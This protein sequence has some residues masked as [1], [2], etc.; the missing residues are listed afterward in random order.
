MFKKIILSLICCVLIITGISFANDASMFFDRFGGNVYPINNDKIRMKSEV[1]DVYVD[2]YTDVHTG[3]EIVPYVECNFVFENTGDTEETILMGFPGDEG[4]ME[5]GYY[6]NAIQDFVAKV[7]GNDVKVAKQTEVIKHKKTGAGE[8]NSTKTWFTWEVKFRPKEVKKIYNGYTPKWSYPS[9]GVDE[10][11]F[12]Y[13]ITTG[14]GWSGTIGETTVN[15]H[16]SNRMKEEWDYWKTNSAKYLT[17]EDDKIIYHRTDYEP[18]D[19]IRFTVGKVYGEVRTLEGKNICINAGHQGKGNPELERYS[20]ISDKKKAKVTSGAKGEAEL[21]LKIAKIL[22]KY[23]ECYGANVMMIRET[24][25]VNISNVERALEGNKSDLVL[26]IHCNGADNKKVWG[27]WILSPARDMLGNSDIYEPSKLLANYLSKTI[28][29]RNIS[30]HERSDLTGLNWSKVPSIFIE[31]GFLSNSKDAEFLNDIT[32]EELTSGIDG[33]LTDVKG[34]DFY[35]G[36]CKAITR[37]FC[38]YENLTQV[39]SNDLI[40]EEINFERPKV[41]QLHSNVREPKNN[42][43]KYWVI[44]ICIVLVIGTFAVMRKNNFFRSK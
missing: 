36:I 9:D 30:V 39:S 32:G 1:I 16:I 2:E 28:K 20:P 29:D 26:N 5:S 35:D 38:G 10:M 4:E 27:T 18:E 40:V 33:T 7:D 17:L 34:V 13:I 44:G 31:C 19:D 12:G 21:N 24:A 6:G 15:F 8:Y 43:E 23:L 41:E 3:K 37:F 42:F 22:K 11:R 14:K 25:D